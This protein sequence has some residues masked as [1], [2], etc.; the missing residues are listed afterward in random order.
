MYGFHIILIL[1]LIFSIIDVG[2]AAIKTPFQG[3]NYYALVIGNN[4]YDDKYGVW[5]S[6]NNP[7]NDAKAVVDVLKRRYTFTEGDIQLLIN[8]KRRDIIR[9]INELIG[10][11]NAKDSVLIFYA[12]HGYLNEDT[13]EAYWVPVDAQGEDETNYIS[14][15]TIKRKLGVIADRASHVLL[16]SDS[17]FSGTLVRGNLSVPEKTTINYYRNKA[18]KKS[19]QIVAAGGKEY[20]KENHRSTGHS[21]FSYFFV[22]EL[23]NNKKQYLSVSE[24]MINIEINVTNNS[25]QTPE[26]GRLYGAGDESGEFIF[27]H[28]KLSEEDR[29]KEIRK[30][31]NIAEKYYRQ[32]LYV[33]Q[34]GK[35]ARMYWDEVL[36]L[37]P[38]NRTAIQGLERI[39]KY[40]VDQ[41]KKQIQINKRNEA[42]K[43]LKIA[44]DVMPDYQS[45]KSMQE[46]LDRLESHIQSSPGF[47]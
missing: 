20:V 38:K 15:E 39:A 9:A 5:D 41:A 35:N 32:K 28:V 19:V 42:K 31:L 4:I 14:H 33:S 30:L 47:W 44:K 8:A 26:I 43:N 36:R 16:V 21:P 37:D 46:E 34:D 12:G 1:C 23:K 11:I 29:Q 10:K 2:S 24:F 18:N 22:H 3:G 45:I 7:I 17:C 40:Y 25:S 27:T 6:L 13:D